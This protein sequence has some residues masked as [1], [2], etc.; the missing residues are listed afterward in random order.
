MNKDQIQA[1][2]R[3]YAWLGSDD[4]KDREVACIMSQDH[5][6]WIE[7][8]AEKFAGQAVDDEQAKEALGYALSELYE[9]HDEPHQ[10][11]C[12]RYRED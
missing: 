12:P 4:E 3:G 11:T 10:E 5:W 9:C 2:V 6:Q 7:A 8:R 1:W